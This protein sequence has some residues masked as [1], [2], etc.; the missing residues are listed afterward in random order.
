[1][2]SMN[3][4]LTG[5][6]ALSHIFDNVGQHATQLRN[7]IRDATRDAGNSL[8]SFTTN[9]GNQLSQ[10][11]RDTDAGGKSIDALKKAT[12]LLAPAAI[13]AAASLAPIAAGAGTVAV[14]LGVMGAALGPQIAKLGEAADAQKAYE[15]AVTQSGA[16]SQDAVK[17]QE[18]VVQAMAALPPETRKTAA[19]LG[20]LKDNYKEWSDALAPDTMAPLNKGIAITNALLPKTS[21]LV[22]VT[23]AEADRFT[24][25]IGGEMSSPGLDR[26][27]GKFT[28][29]SQRTL[30]SVNDQI[31]HLLRLS[32]SG[33]VGGNARQFMDWARAQGPTVASVLTSI[34]TALMNVL[35]AGSEVGVGLL[36][37][38]E[39]IADLVSAVPPGTIA[40]FLQL[41]L[42]LK[43]TKAAALGLVAAR[44]ALAGFGVSMVAMNTA[45]TAAPTRLAAVQAAIGSLSRTTKVAMAG[46][47]IGLLVIALSELSQR[48]RQAP[49][50]VD[51]LTSSLRELG[52][53]GRVTGEAAKHFGS[54]LDGMYDKVR[55]LTDPSTLDKVQ[56]FLVGWTGWDSTPVKEAKEQLNSVDEAL[57]NLVRGGQSDL[58][59]AALQRLTAEYGKGGRDTREFT[60]ELDSYKSAVADAKFEQ[61]LAAQSMGL[62]GSQAQ[63]VQTQLDG[64]KRSADG[65]R[66][67]IAALNDIQRR[68]LGGMIGFEAAIDAAADAA[69]KNAGALEMTGGK[70]DLNSEKARTAAAALQDLA[71]KT[72]EAA[73]SARESGSSWETVNGIYSRGRDALMKTAQAMGLSRSEAAQ[74]ANQI[75]K[76]PDKTAR[77]RMS[78]EDAVQD[79]NAFNAKVRAAPGSKSVTLKTISSAAE[80]VLKTFGYKVTHLPNGSVKISASGGQALGVISSVRGAVAALHD[81]HIVLTTEKRTIY[82]GKGGRGPNAYAAGGTP[83]AGE[84]A[85]VGEEGPEL[86]VFGQAARVFD[87]KTTK[88]LLN[89]TL[90]AGGS[91]AAGLAAGLGSTDGVYSAARVMAGA[92]TAGIRDELEIRS[93]SKKTKALA[94]D[95]GKGFISG[96][97]G[98]R[99]KIKSVAADLAKDIKTAFTGKK[100][101]NL[102][103]SVE[104]QTKKLLEAAAKRDAIAK[105]IADAKAYAADTTKTARD[106]ASLSS[107]GMDADQ[108][109]AGGIKG[110]LAA[111]LAQIKQ[112]SKYVDI[113]A[114]RGLNKGL[115]RQILNMGP[116]AGY[117]YASALAG[118]DKTTIASI[119]K[120]QSAI[121]SE[122]KKLGD[123]GADILYDSG[124]NAGKGFLKGLEGQQKDIEK[125]MLKIAQGMQ[126]SIKRALGIKSPSTVMAKLGAHSTEGLARGL[127][128]GLPSLD[129]SLARVS[130]RVSGIQ[131]VLGRPAVGGRNGAGTVIHLHVDG[132]VV[133]TLGFARAA[134]QALLELKRA[135]GFADLGIA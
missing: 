52:N 93:P 114:K 135:H 38:V 29:F 2:P 109:T 6:D 92:V 31:V 5:Q 91:A 69:S 94:Q 48:G 11:Q 95:V 64:Q 77:V 105:K 59:A 27:T 18:A 80:A 84:L 9:A 32:G 98:S 97:T 104:R 4:L 96:L 34:T 19:A 133:D 123:K 41:A 20:I 110:G 83:R 113:L 106:Q 129:R 30:R 126:R 125:L 134:R 24:T 73:S 37:A 132:A 7:R 61:E 124:K 62:F 46:T 116:E 118:A 87:A 89:R 47:G 74:L 90:T 55:S 13:P 102:L 88:S 78:T 117:A 81:R 85:M 79:L 75:L 121:D 17:K 33:E 58:A 26:V 42:A 127:V 130:G 120:T 76:I 12:M 53:T 54:D 10:L 131:P 45:A 56:Q 82:T 65:L 70:L 15:D 99:D 112:F 68:G 44:S 35:E 1:M 100:E 51:R 50:D 72:D 49:P 43:V 66:Q 128:E 21:G 108:V 36:Q 8:N 115:I 103:K 86:V 111:K 60:K 23:A 28:S 107:L 14:A 39:V 119:N 22:K 57:A 122:T 16:R 101:S 63:K 25:I 67:S 71:S 3:F 40:L